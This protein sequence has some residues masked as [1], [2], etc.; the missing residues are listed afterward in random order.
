LGVALINEA[1]DYAERL[2]AETREEIARADAKA[3]ILLGAGGVATSIASTALFG[4]WNPARLKP[5]GTSVWWI[6]ASLAGCAL[7]CLGSAVYP[8]T[9]AVSPR[10]RQSHQREPRPV[11][12]FVQ[13]AGCEDLATA[14][15]AIEAAA[16][17]SVNR[18]VE[19]AWSLSKLVMTK[20]RLTRAA[21][22]LYATSAMLMVFARV[23]G[24]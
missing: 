2:L 19:Q 7:L 21:L 5:W 20:Y 1:R 23:I 12:Y 13:L 24:S 8:R 10:G 17:D 11:H 14:R 3:S 15:R 4:G 6:G 16:I 18:A 9:G 22:W